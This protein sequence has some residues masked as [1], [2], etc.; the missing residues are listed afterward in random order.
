MS[1]WTLRPRRAQPPLSLPQV[2]ISSN[3]HP[4]LPSSVNPLSSPAPFGGPQPLTPLALAAVATVVGATAAG[5]A[6]VGVAVAIVVAT[7]TVAGVA[8]AA[9]AAPLH[10][11]PARA[12]AAPPGRPS[13]IPGLTPSTCGRARPGH[14]SHPNRRTPSLLHRRWGHRS[15]LLWR[16]C[17]FLVLRHLSSSPGRRGQGRGIHSSSLAPSAP[18]SSLSP[19]PPPTEWLT[20]APLATPPRTQVASPLPAPFGFPSLLVMVPFYPSPQ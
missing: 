7:T 6:V 19:R 4:P 5:V 3:L 18:W 17:L 14:L 11:L 8:A 15:R 13:T 9:P 2:D 20:L 10:R 12:E 1:L 16:L